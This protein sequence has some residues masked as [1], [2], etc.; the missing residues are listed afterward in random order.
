MAAAA[1]ASDICTV[2]LI[3][4]DADTRDVTARLLRSAGCLVRATPSVG[5]AL[6]VLEEWMPSHIL[7]DLMLPDAGG[8]V[9]LRSVRRRSLPVRVAVLTAAGPDSPVVTDAL[10]WQ[11]D[12]VF[13][14]P[15]VFSEVESW[16]AQA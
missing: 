7:L 15:I 9:I 8:V 3:E 10:R 1:A 12:A 14:K 5:E 11:P 16:L 6:L 2:L 13:H 4:D